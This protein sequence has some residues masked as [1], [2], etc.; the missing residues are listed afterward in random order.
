DA[1]S[2]QCDA[3][4]APLAEGELIDPRSKNTKSPVEL[5]STEHDFVDWKKLQPLLEQYFEKS[6]GSWRDWVRA[7][8]GK[9]LREGLR[10]RAITRDLDWGVEIPVERMKVEDRIESASSK[11]IY[12]WF[13]AVIGYLSASMEWAT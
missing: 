7:E 5:N 12:V 2:D 3:C 13:D 1:R 11:R 9:W 4:G 6:S 10:A 8:T